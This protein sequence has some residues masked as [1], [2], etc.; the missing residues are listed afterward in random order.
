M[1]HASTVLYNIPSVCHSHQT[2]FALPTRKRVNFDL[3]G[4]LALGWMMVDGSVTNGGEA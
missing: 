4:N 1:L 3:E 2:S